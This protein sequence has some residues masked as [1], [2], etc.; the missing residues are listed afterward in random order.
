MGVDLTA[1]AGAEAWLER[2]GD[3]QAL[4]ESSL[5]V[6]GKSDHDLSILL[7]DDAR[8]RELNRDY[9]GKDSAT[10]VLS[11]G[12]LE[13]E[14]FATPVPVLGDLVISLETADRQA[15][16]QGHPLGA[17]VR[18]LLVHGVLHL[19]GHDHMDDGQRAAMARAEN[20]LLRRLP[21]VPEWPTGSGLIE[22]AG[23]E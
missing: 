18:I 23:G 16:E 11:F 20:A 2:A 7:T 6:L 19:L 4:A 8:I 21:S 1:E 14:G 9:R 12:Q 3:I 22:R 15:T 10:D 13:G 5:D 17:E